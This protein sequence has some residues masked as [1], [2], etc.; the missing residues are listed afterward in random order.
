VDGELYRRFEV[1]PRV[2]IQSEDKV[3]IFVGGGSKKIKLRLKSHS[4]NVTGVVRLMG[5]AAW[6]IAPAGIPFSLPGKRDEVEVAFEVS[7]PKQTAAA[8]LT[9]EAET[10][11]QKS[12]R[13]LVEIAYPHIHRQVYFPE[14][15]LRVVRLDIRTEGKRLGYIMGAGDEVPRALQNLGYEVVELS[16]EMLGNADLASFDAVIAGVRAYDT[17]EGLRE[18]KDRLLRYVENG[19][20]LVVQYN[21]A[22][23]QEGSQ[24]GPYPLTIGRDRVSVEDAPVV[25]LAPDHPLLNFPNKITAADFDGWIQER[26]LYFASQ[27]D[28]RYEPVLSSHD[29]GEPEKKGGLL[30]ARHGRGVFIYTGYSWFRQLPAGVPGAFRLFSNMIAAGRS[31]GKPNEARY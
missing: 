26:G 31:L 24:V 12:S 23:N 13:T 17:R 29:P 4:P 8:D 27:W 3:G 6:K 18:S 25:F 7:P 20:T 30:Y 5:P 10:G 22:W 19:G 21:V 28:E 11:G 9:A 16:D 14:S 1:R 15:R 2:T